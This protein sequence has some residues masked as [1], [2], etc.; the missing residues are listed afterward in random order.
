MCDKCEVCGANLDYGE[1][2]ECRGDK[3]R[4][5]VLEEQERE[6]TAQ[7]QQE[8][9]DRECAEAVERIPALGRIKALIDTRA[10]EG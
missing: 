10:A 7:V 2:C 5:A 9:I 3:K 4:A 6:Y 1:V 8:R